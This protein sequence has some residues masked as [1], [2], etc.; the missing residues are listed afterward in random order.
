MKK[1]AGISITALSIMVILCFWL[2][3]K[4]K[5]SRKII[6]TP[7]QKREHKHSDPISE[8]KAN[9]DT[10]VNKKTGSEAEKIAVKTKVKKA[11]R[12]QTEDIKFRDVK[13]KHFGRGAYFE[14]LPIDDTLSDLDNDS[15]E[16][17]EI[18]F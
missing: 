16:T 17:K 13:M 1:Y 11:P 18:I 2:V 12:Q 3:P 7:I 9:S 4:T 14:E 10:T 8:R 15:S 5:A 6:Y